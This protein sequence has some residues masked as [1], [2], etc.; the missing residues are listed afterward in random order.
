MMT[1][2]P[3]CGSTE[4]ISGL[5][6]LTEETTSGG[7]PAYVKLLEPEPAK[8][9]FMWVR[10]EVKSEFQAAVCGNCGHTQIYANSPSEILEA[11]KKGF[12]SD[13]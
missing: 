6:L 8:R 9:P 2:C 3:E 4:I 12:T 1:K 11:F 5:N 7:R 13:G 10:Q